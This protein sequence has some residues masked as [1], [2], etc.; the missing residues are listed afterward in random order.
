MRAALELVLS[1]EQRWM[2]ATDALKLR[3]YASASQLMKE[4][5]RFISDATKGCVW[6]LQSKRV[7]RVKCPISPRY[8][9][10]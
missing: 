2:Q 4:T 10:F 8:D 6:V 7:I 3:K 9:T 1:A 5:K